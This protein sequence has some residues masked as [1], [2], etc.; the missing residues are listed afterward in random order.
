MGYMYCSNT[1]G[2]APN[3]YP[4]SFCGPLDHPSY[5]LSKTTYVSC[6]CMLHV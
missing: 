3:Y 4:N 1:T 6:V 5:A 2:G